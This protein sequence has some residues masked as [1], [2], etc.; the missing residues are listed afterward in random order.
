VELAG[1]RVLG[2][3]FQGLNIPSA[4]GQAA[5]HQNAANGYDYEEYQLDQVALCLNG[6]I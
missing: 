2:L 1:L 5:Q 3:H 4:E 6:K